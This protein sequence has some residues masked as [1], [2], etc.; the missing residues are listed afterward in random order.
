[1]QETDAITPS[2]YR[3]SRHLASTAARRHDDARGGTSLLEVCWGRR[4]TIAL[5]VLLC[6]AGAVLY[7]LNAPRVYTPSAS[8]YV[9]A[10]GLHLLG[11]D[12]EQSA[13]DAES[14]LFRQCEL[15]KSERVVRQVV[16]T[17]PAVMRLLYPRSPD[18]VA[19]VRN[20]LSVTV[21]KKDD[22]ITVALNCTRPAEGAALINAIV[23]AYQRSEKDQ[24]HTTASDAVAILR[25]EKAKQEQALDDKQR[26]IVA[27]KQANGEMFFSNEHGTN[28]L[29]Q[30]LAMISD[31]VTRAR[32]EAIEQRALYLDSNGTA[33]DRAWRQAEEK[34]KDKENLY[35]QEKVKA[36]RINAALAEYE[37]LK[38][39]A[40][41]VTKQC[42]L[43]DARIRELD[44]TQQGGPDI[45]V[46]EA[47]KDEPRPTSPKKAV[48]LIAALAAGLMLGCG[49]A[50]LRDGL[51]QQLRTSTIA[52]RL[53]GAPV[54]AELPDAAR[55][56]PT[57]RFSLA[58]I[59]Q[60]SPESDLAGA[61]ESLA[62]EI[63]YGRSFRNGCSL[64]VTS[65]HR[66]DGKTTVA[67]NLAIAAAQ[68][69]RRT[70]L[71][72]ADL[73]KPILHKVFDLPGR[74]GIADMVVDGVTLEEAVRPTS[75]RGLSLLAAGTLSGS[76]AEVVGSPEFARLVREMESEFDLIVLDA[77]PLL[78]TGD[79]RVLAAHADAALVVLRAQRS[80]RQAAK[81]AC[82][83]VVGVGCTLLGFAYNGVD[84]AG[85]YGGAPP[86]GRDERISIRGGEVRPDDRQGS[87]PVT[88]PRAALDLI[89]TNGMRPANIELATRAPEPI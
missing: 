71:I 27:C 83:R 52:A 39:D 42:D 4:W 38:S 81:Q 22:V 25:S 29:I 13:A 67:A 62:A 28:I 3:P 24:A 78:G 79:A 10:N 16:E 88:S 49:L 75:V 30:N 31:Q 60:L 19:D 45:R 50:V 44:V 58:R 77:P 51:D 82:D 63:C 20:D 21:G 47:A 41:R 11:K 70:L 9:D 32:L 15:I 2:P 87:A 5:S 80:S 40:D 36:L 54:L 37:K 68:A 17:R 35:E 7:I 61:F 14:F 6:L 34:A 76:P 73:R 74:L 89:P 23:D 48:A 59:T 18:P 86:A 55:L 84:T 8:L 65:P 26:E 66:G 43:L 85:T 56:G 12:K 72:D 53:L 33:T 64:L 46:L 69:G 57:D 1:M